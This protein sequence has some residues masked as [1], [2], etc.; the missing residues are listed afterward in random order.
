[1][2]REIKFRG[3]D[4]IA[5]GW[6]LGSP[7]MD[8]DVKG[9][10]WIMF[11]ESEGAIIDRPETIGQFTGLKDKNGT[12]IFEGDIVAWSSFKEGGILKPILKNSEIIYYSKEAKFTIKGNEIW[13]LIYSNIEVIGNIHQNPEFL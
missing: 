2:S 9:R 12:D 1:M 3:Y 5:Q 10:W 8:K 7:V 11:D 6:C 13:G 4:D